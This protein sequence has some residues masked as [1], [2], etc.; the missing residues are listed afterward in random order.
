MFKGDLKEY[1]ATNTITDAESTNLRKEFLNYLNLI[2]SP[3]K[4][5]LKT[6]TPIMLLRNLNQPKLYNEILITGYSDA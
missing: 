6:I 2:F 4:L 3:Y 1:S 5:E